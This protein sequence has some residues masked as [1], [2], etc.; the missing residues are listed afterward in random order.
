[1]ASIN[2]ELLFELLII[3]HFALNV[4]FGVR[5]IYSRR[6]TESAMAW[7]VVL[8]ALPYIGTVSYLLFGEPRL[9]KKRMKR[10]EDIMDFYYQF[11]QRA[12][13]STD[14][15]RTK[16]RI[17]EPFWRL[18]QISAGKTFLPIGD[19]NRVTLLQD[20]DTIITHMIDDIHRAQHT[21]L[22]MF[23]IVSAE[24]RVDD[25]LNALI[26]AA[27]RGVACKLLVDALGGRAFFKS[28]WPKRLTAAGVNVQ[29]SLSIGWLSILF[30]RSDLRNHRKLVIVDYR[31]A[32]TGSYNLVD[33]AYFGKNAGV[34][35]W[36]DAMMR[37]EGPS[38]RA[39][40]AVFYSDW[41]VENDQQLAET[42][43]YVQPYFSHNIDLSEYNQSAGRLATSQP[44]A[45]EAFTGE[46]L[47]EEALIQVI[48]SAPD[49]SFYVLYNT[50][51]SAMYLAQKRIVITTPYFVPDEALLAAL[52]NAARRGV[53]VV[54]ILPEKNNSWWVS[55]ASK[56]YYHILL[57]EGVYLAK[58]RLGFLHAKT[59]VID[60]DYALF[61]T[62]NMDMR[63]FYL[64][65]EIALAIYD[66]ATVN[67]I[68]DMQQGYL[69]HCESVN[70]K[71]WQKRPLLQRF[72]ERCVRLASPFL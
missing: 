43:D 49:K 24:G 48:P 38:V 32:Y 31:V 70:L 52:C 13:P 29:Q 61:G 9:G 11:C 41:A 69:Q 23:Y 34:G 19:N 6:S 30:V 35:Q 53:D 22:L 51:L 4:F 15:Q 45:G 67:Q 64:N 39:L 50:L 36:K 60:S 26:A 42:I 54:I 28:D 8:F 21:C 68:S 25:V 56:A 37:C 12:F 72:V 63:S 44:R 14:R 33:P 16:S 58:Y 7:L 1:M 18:S 10:M 62:V 27:K 66:K 17:N 59:V 47:T 71:K 55:Q 46:T 65:M 57:T 40:T 20:T 2:S 5:V 3:G